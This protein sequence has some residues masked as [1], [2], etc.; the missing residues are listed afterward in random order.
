MEHF[1]NRP[2]GGLKNSKRYELLQFQWLL[3]LLERVRVKRRKT[4]R[5]AQMLLA[6][7]WLTFEKVLDANAAGRA[8][9]DALL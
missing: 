7:L 1:L 5:L 3:V 8:V 6:V 9:V 2:G 4:R